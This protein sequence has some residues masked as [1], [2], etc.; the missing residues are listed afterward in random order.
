MPYRGKG[1]GPP[2]GMK[3]SWC[4]WWRWAIGT[5]TSFQRRAESRGTLDLVVAVA[6]P[7]RGVDAWVDVWLLVGYW[8]DMMD[9]SKLVGDG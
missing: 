3:K 4:G 7:P 6:K 1:R 2:A 9:D 5:L 8:L